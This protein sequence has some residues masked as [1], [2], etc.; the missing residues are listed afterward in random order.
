MDIRHLFRVS[1]I[2]FCINSLTSRSI[3]GKGDG[4]TSQ[5]EPSVPVGIDEFVKEMGINKP[6]NRLSKADLIT[7]FRQLEKKQYANES[8]SEMNELQ[9]RVNE[10]RNKVA[11]MKAIMLRKP[12]FGG[13]AIRT[14]RTKT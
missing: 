8:E 2:F 13:D 4:Q 7:I 11:R 9:D 12:L 10:L 14:K 3:P 5:R 6:F 1:V